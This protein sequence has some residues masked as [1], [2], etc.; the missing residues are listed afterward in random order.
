[1]E[2][3]GCWL[4]SNRRIAGLFTP[5]GNDGATSDI[6]SRT[7]FA[8]SSGEWLSLN[9]IT[10]TESDSEEVER[11]CST[12]LMEPTASSIGLETSVSTSVGPAP[13]NVV[14]TATMGNDT[15]GKRFTPMRVYD[16]PPNTTAAAK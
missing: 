5:S 1:M 8:P 2:R 16:I 6:R 12:P 3:T 15:S 7:A 4:G 13:G 11:T 10:T 9:S 14:L